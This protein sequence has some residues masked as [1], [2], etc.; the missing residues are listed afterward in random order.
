MIGKA[1]WNR[2]IA[3]E[4][5][6]RLAGG[7]YR[8]QVFI[9][10]EAKAIALTQE[11]ARDAGH[12]RYVVLRKSRKSYMNN[13]ACFRGESITSGKQEY[14]IEEDDLDYLAGREVIVVDD[15]IS[16]GKTAQ[17]FLEVTA[18]SRSRVSCFCCA[19][20]EGTE[21]KELKGIP[22]ISLGHIPLPGLPPEGAL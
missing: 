12:D 6:D 5:L 20:T 4:L 13:P 22:V 7:A 14:W 19:L 16:S 8:P 18:H 10:A 3:R 9:T 2:L 21:W 1:G 15:V 11:L 17:T